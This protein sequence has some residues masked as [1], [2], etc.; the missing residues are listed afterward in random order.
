MI[1]AALVLVT[2]AALFMFFLQAVSA[3]ILRRE[4]KYAYFKLIANTNGLEFPSLR[5]AL[6][7]DDQRIK[8]EQLRL[9]LAC[10]YKALTFLLRKVEAPGPYRVSVEE[11][12]LSSYCHL[13]FLA[14]SLRHSLGLQVK[15]AALKLAAIL[16]HFANV[17]GYRVEVVRAGNLNVVS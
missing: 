11:R 14:M 7:E 4:F 2:S 8:Y 16:E 5:A 10:D 13:L 6:E 17:V 12:F 3:R 9:A 1:L 15:P